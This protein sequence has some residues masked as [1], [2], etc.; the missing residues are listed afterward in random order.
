MATRKMTTV[1]VRASRQQLARWGGA[2]QYEGAASIGAWLASL[3]S[4]RLR[5][6]GS[7]VPRLVLRWRRS[8]FNALRLPYFNAPEAT[9]HEVS[10]IVAGPFGIYKDPREPLPG[11]EPPPV[12]HLVHVPT[13]SHLAKLPLRK[14]C[15][16]LARELATYRVTWDTAVPEEVTGPEMW[17]VHSAIRQ[18][19]TA[20]YGS[21]ITGRKEGEQRG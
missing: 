3:A 18:A 7:F 4:A 1:T 17:K 6:L 10:G 13:G 19:Q 14:R 20:A 11:P 9:L 12:F 8:P 16:S 5:Y 21:P 15:K 2:A